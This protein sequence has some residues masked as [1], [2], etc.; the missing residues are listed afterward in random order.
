MYRKPWVLLF[1]GLAIV[2]Q[3]IGFDTI[4][5][6]Q[7]EVKLDASLVELGETFRLVYKITNS[8]DKNIEQ[9]QITE[10]IYNKNNEVEESKTSKI[11]GGIS[12]NSQRDIDGETHNAIEGYIHYLVEY[13]MEGEEGWVK[14]REGEVTLNLINIDIKVTYKAKHPDKVMKGEEVQYTAVIQ[15]TSNV[16]LKNV[17]VLDTKL[18]ELGNISVL[19]PGEKKTITKYFKLQETTESHIIVQHDHPINGQEQMTHNLTNAK[20]KVK[21]EEESPVYSLEVVGAVDKPYIPSPE[22][23]TFTLRL[24]NS[25]NAALINVQCIDWNG[26]VFF[27]VD[28]LAPNKDVTTE[29]T[30]KVSPD[31]SYEIICSGMVEDGS[32]KVQSSYTAQILK[33]APKIEIERRFTPE[34]TV[35]G[36]TVTIEYTIRNTGNITLM[37]VKVDEPELGGIASFD[38]LKP[39]E[40]K[41]FSIEKIMDE[42]GIISKTIVTAREEETGNPYRYEADELVIPAKATGQ[43]AHVSISVTVNPEQ[44]GEAGSVE[45]LCTVRNDGEVTLNNVEVI[46]KERNIPMGSVLELNPGDEETF[47]I[48]QLGMEET[49]SFTI[50]VKAQAQQGNYVEFS[51]EPFEIIVGGEDAQGDSASDTGKAMLLKTVFIV[52]IFL[53]ILTAGVLLYM[54]RDSL[55]FFRNRKNQKKHKVTQ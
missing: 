48:S 20:V 26:N 28:R 2:V 34:E 24:K 14:L 51:S 33:T 50:V 1:I 44:L 11:D 21:V 31:K 16:P 52:I 38:S 29:Y 12:L 46:L 18:G 19:N 36:D 42:D 9:I 22:E 37:D 32:Q 30:V 5:L 27:Q 53:I 55:P 35:P 40:T 10:T 25:G 45:L 39:G 7:G 47:K 15:S 3:M 17:T 4:T 54:V 8:T 41:D 6:A 49:E 43:V 23:V 13:R